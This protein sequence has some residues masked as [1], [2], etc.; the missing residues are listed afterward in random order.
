MI[1]GLIIVEKLNIMGIQDDTLIMK[2]L[3]IMSKRSKFFVSH[4]AYLLLQ[5]FSPAVFRLLS[6]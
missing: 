1:L 5:F 3:E 2:A 6:Y 4:F